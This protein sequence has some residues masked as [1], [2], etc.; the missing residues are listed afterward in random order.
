[1]QAEVEIESFGINSHFDGAMAKGS[2]GGLNVGVSPNS[3][4]IQHAQSFLACDV[5]HPS[6]PSSECTL[7]ASPN[8]PQIPILG[9]SMTNICV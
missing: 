1:M 5:Q 7:P 3:L 2:R 6:Q 4:H 9:K 8:T